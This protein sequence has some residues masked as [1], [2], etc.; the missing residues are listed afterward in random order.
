MGRNR[1]RRNQGREE[2]AIEIETTRQSKNKKRPNG[3]RLLTRIIG[4]SGRGKK[5][6][7][8]KEDI[9]GRSFYIKRV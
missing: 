7:G 3:A 2:G 4:M 6:R 8:I 1:E 9:G 5:R